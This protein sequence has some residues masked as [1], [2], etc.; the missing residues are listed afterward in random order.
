VR[1]NSEWFGDWGWS[2]PFHDTNN[3]VPPD[4]WIAGFRN[5]VSV[6]R[7]DSDTTLSHIKIEWDYPICSNGGANGPGES[8]YPGDDYVDIIGTDVYAQRQWSPVD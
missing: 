1:I 6:I 8:Y 3:I 2:S 5:L 7:S 4:I